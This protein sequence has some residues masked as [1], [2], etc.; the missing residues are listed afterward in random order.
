MHILS[1]QKRIQLSSSFPPFPPNPLKH[2]ENASGIQY[3]VSQLLLK[4]WHFYNT[5]FMKVVKTITVFAVIDRFLL[6]FIGRRQGEREREAD[7]ER[8]GGEVERGREKVEQ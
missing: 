7:R 4:Q 3:S 1:I 5:F 6:A 2:I 8:R